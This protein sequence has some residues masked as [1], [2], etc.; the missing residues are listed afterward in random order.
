MKITIETI[1][2]K[3]QRYPTPGDWFF[4]KEGDLTIRVSSLGDWRYEAIMAV[5]ELVEV[6]L[7]KHAGVTQEAVDQFDMQY[8]KDRKKG[9][10]GKLDEPGDNNQAPYREQHSIATGVERILGA[11]LGIAW[12]DYAAAVERLED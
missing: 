6:C 10:H 1:P 5:H 2:H 11:G 4:D 8:E 7:C 12:N 9:K 3:D